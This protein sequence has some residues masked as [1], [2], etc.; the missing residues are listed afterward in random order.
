MLMDTIA[1][2]TTKFPPLQ[3]HAIGGTLNALGGGVDVHVEQKH[4]GG[5][6]RVDRNLPDRA[7]G[8]H[9]QTAGMPLIHHVRQQESIAHDGLSCVERRAD[10]LFDKLR[11]SRHVQQHF[12]A[13]MD[14]QIVA[15]EQQ[16]PDRFAQRCA[17][18]IATSHD[19]VAQS[20]Q[21]IA[22][23]RYLRGFAN[24]VDPVEAEEHRLRIIDR[25]RGIRRGRD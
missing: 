19:V 4:F 14:R 5:H 22:E 3:F 11:S 8:L 12:G 6:D 18:G 23:L 20:A 10:H 13:T 15:I 1:N 24:T 25:A 21:P 9:V 17:A 2:T 7:Y 16:T